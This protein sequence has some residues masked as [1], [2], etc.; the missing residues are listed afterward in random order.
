MMMLSLGTAGAGPGQGAFTGYVA[1]QSAHFQSGHL[2][3]VLYPNALRLRGPSGVA[4]RAHALVVEALTG[5]PDMFSEGV[6]RCAGDRPADPADGDEFSR[7]LCRRR[8]S[9]HQ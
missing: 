2:K 1:D 6:V 9:W 7:W 5:C 3:A 4:A 8:I